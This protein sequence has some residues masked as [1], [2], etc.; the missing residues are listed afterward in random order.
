MA[1]DTHDFEFYREPQGQ[2]HGSSRA[3]T[4]THFVNGGGGAYLSIGTSLDWPKPPG[5]ADWA[6]YPGTDAVRTKLE[7]E[8]PAWKR[9]FWWWLTLANAWPSSPETFSGIF[10]FNRAPYFQSFMEVRVEGSKNQVRLVL[11]G[12]DGP[13]KWRDL[14]KGGDVVEKG[15]SLDSAVEFV[16]PMPNQSLP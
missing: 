9:P 11:Y 5:T 13:L 4:M 12:A 10:D 1:G 3:V 14:Q 8:T 15:Q 7:R 6:F 16:L 2:G